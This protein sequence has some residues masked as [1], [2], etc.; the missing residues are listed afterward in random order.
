MLEYLDQRL[1]GEA[2]MLLALA[3]NW[4]DMAEGQIR[5]VGLWWWTNVIGRSGAE[6]LGRFIP[7]EK[8]M[9]QAH[10]V[11]FLTVEGV[12]TNRPGLPLV[13][14]ERLG[15][16]LFGQGRTGLR[17]LSFCN[18]GAMGLGLVVL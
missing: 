14:K 8:E 18:R 2:H 17:L 10:W 13:P 7:A 6:G 12:G 15:C 11:D 3:L 9:L 1:K 5:I 4:G 16:D